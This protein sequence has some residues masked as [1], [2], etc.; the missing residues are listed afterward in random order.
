MVNMLALILKIRVPMD[1]TLFFSGY[2]GDDDNE[3]MF[4]EFD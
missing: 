1:P 2:E 3:K 4:S